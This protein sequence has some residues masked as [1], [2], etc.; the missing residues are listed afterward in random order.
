MSTTVAYKGNVIHTAE[1]STSFTLNT[2]GNYLDGNV[3]V[4]VSES[5]GGQSS[6][7]VPK[8]ITQNGTYDPANDNA[9][10]YSE[11]TVNVSG[12]SGSCAIVEPDYRGLS[13][14]YISTQQGFHGSASK[15]NCLNLFPVIANHQYIIYLGSA[16]GN[17]YRVH[18]YSGKTISDFEQ[19]I[20][21]A[22]A[23]TSQIYTCTNNI[24]GS[25]D[26]ENYSRG[27]IFTP[28]SNGMI[29]VSTSNQSVI[30]PA[31]CI[32]ASATP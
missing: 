21:N 4:V 30:V 13:Y 23:N 16:H 3:E 12:G 28:N 26:L 11:V 19:Y 24:S 18:F 9:D 29:I 32:D 5:G 27:Y 8:S 7:L 1:G 6:V 10:G 20:N 17:R 31:Y 15:D 14:A 2:Q 22:S 25:A